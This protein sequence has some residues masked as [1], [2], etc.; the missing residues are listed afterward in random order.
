MDASLIPWQYSTRTIMTMNEEPHH[1]THMRQYSKE[2]YLWVQV[3]LL[4]ERDLSVM[5]NPIQRD[6][7]D[8]E[9]T[10]LPRPDT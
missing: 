9:Q 4:H 1:H 8:T 6:P 10:K 2:I 3:V 5:Q 7:N